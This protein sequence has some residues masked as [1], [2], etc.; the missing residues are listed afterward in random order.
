MKNTM[1]YVNIIM[2]LC[3]CLLCVK[4]S[5]QIWASQDIKEGDKENEIFVEGN[6][7]TQEIQ[8]TE[9][10]TVRID[11][12]PY[13]E[14]EGTNWN[15]HVKGEEKMNLLEFYPEHGYA[16]IQG[17]EEGNA[18]LEAVL[19]N[20]DGHILVNLVWNIHISKASASSEKQPANPS[21]SKENS[22]GNSDVG[23][24]TNQ[25]EKTDTS[26]K[27]K[28]IKSEIVK[29]SQKKLALYI[30]IK[31]CSEAKHYLVY[32]SSDKK[33]G[34]K[35]IGTAKK[36]IYKDSGVK[37]GKTYYYKVKAVLKDKYKQNNS[38][39][40]ESKPKKKKAG[41]YLSAPKIKAKLTKEQLKISGGKVSAGTGV[42]VYVKE[43]GRAYIKAA[44][45]Y[46]TKKRQKLMFKISRSQFQSRSA[47]FIKI[48]IFQKANKKTIYSKFSNT[49]SV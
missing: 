20:Q 29:I 5:P 25:K 15:W 33:K 45:H 32:R 44:S 11:I 39:S 13:E 34:Y 41:F 48:R 30:Q 49:I 16:R 46:Y 40:I 22:K 35:K 23:K 12:P 38:I 36:T 47:C 2:I 43:K 4:Q 27:T 26:V 24:T 21:A 1:G 42:E 28:K 8:L 31:P 10:E 7:Y 18:V 6:L 37:G 14:Q 19:C 3:I 9:G 17:K